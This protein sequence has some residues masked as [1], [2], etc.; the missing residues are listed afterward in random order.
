MFASWLHFLAMFLLTSI[1]LRYI[2]VT[3]A[4]REFAKALMFIH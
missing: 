3:F 4:D 1:F 2:E